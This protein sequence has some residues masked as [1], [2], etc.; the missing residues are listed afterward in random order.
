ML[1]APATLR[2]VARRAEVHPSTASRALNASTRPMVN[3]ETVERV[4][5]AARELGYEPNSLARGLK[6]NRTFTIGVLVPDLTN[7]L[8]PPIVRGLEDGLGEARYTVV[9]GNTDNDEERETSV[10]EAMGRRRVDGLVLATARRDYPVLDRLEA[11][12]VPLVL[13]NRSSDRPMV[14]SVTGDDHAGIGLAVRHLVQLGH[15]RIA[16]VAGSQ[17]VST[18]LSRY[19]AFVSWLQSEGVDFDPDLVVRADWFQEDP[20]AQAFRELLDRGADFS[21]VVAANDLIA[22]GCYDVAVERGL[23]VPGDFSVV[24]YN[25]IPFSD[26]F[27]P[28]LTTVRIPL[29]QIGLRA[30]Q[31]LLDIIEGR[32]AEP[33]SMRLAPSLV[34]RAS[35][36][37]PPSS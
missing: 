14:S 8:F 2:D 33:V 30:A 21:A 4:L 20:G 17:A 35:T 28:P 27:N 12:G 7:P 34:V 22:L 15:R 37:A 16:H 9:L 24:G 32:E 11:A 31:L 18:G 23:T 5:T 6:T 25:D 19:Q 1:Q 29:Y 3:A 10:L 26:K 13:I 36:A